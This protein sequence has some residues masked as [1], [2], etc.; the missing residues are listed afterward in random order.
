MKSVCWVTA[1]KKNLRCLIEGHICCM[2]SVRVKMFLLQ[3]VVW[4]MESMSGSWREHHHSQSVP[5]CISSSAWT[6]FVVSNRSGASLWGGGASSA[7]RHTVVYLSRPPRGL[8]LW[9]KWSCMQSAFQSIMLQC[10]CP[11]SQTAGWSFHWLWCLFKASQAAFEKRL[12]LQI[13][14]ASCFYVQHTNRLDV[15]L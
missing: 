1:S 3:L 10:L 2:F 12:R 7:L 15:S 4:R 9:K 6:P 8:R 5:A 13:S 11:C 14:A